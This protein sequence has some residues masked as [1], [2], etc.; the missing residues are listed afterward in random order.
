MGDSSSGIRA[1]DGSVGGAVAASVSAGVGDK[2]SLG[3]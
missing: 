1:S 3:E 2:P